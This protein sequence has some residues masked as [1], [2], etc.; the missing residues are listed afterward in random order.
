MS[1]IILSI[2]I[3]S[4]NE[5]D[6]IGKCLQSFYDQSLDRDLFEVLVCDG[7]SNDGTIEIIHQYEKKEGFN[8]NLI[9]NQKRK[10][11]YALNL[12]LKAAKGKYKAIFG[13]HATADTDFCKNSIEFLDNNKNIACVGGVLENIFEN[14]ASKTI[15]LAMSSPFG[16]GNAHFRTGEFEGEVDTVAFGVYRAEVFEDIGYFDEELTR[17]QDDELNFR[18]TKSGRKIFLSKRIKAKYFVRSSFPKLR[19]QYFQYGYW[20][21]FVNKKHQT[22][23]TVRQLIPAFFV[24][25]LLGVLP[26]VL[27]IPFGEIYLSGLLLYLMAAIYFSGKLSKKLNEQF[28]IIK[29]FWILHY[30]YG[31]GY[32]KGILD[33]YLL[34]KNPGIKSEEISR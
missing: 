21:V 23:T 27:F 18:I 31:L 9:E 12:G 34:N 4:Y 15:G 19:R 17:N 29:V 30:N 22:I 33:F 16:V 24:A 5:K 11:P 26:I 20:K 14:E 28:S 6:Y 8:C 25:Y 13:A 3:P 1:D 32:L 7:L 10:T 2:V